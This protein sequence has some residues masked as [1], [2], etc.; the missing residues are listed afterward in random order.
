MK[1]EPDPTMLKEA[2]A[3]AASLQAAKRKADEFAKKA[4]DA[5]MARVK[6][7]VDEWKEREP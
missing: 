2:M 6:A 4:R 5:E 1:K 3:R 7:I